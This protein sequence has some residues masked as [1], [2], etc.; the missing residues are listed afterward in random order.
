MAIQFSVPLINPT[1]RTANQSI[2]LVVSM[3]VSDPVSKAIYAMDE[4]QRQQWFFEFNRTLR[5]LHFMLPFDIN[6]INAN[7]DIGRMSALHLFE[8]WKN[9]KGEAPKMLVAMTNA[10]KHVDSGT[11][12]GIFKGRTDFYFPYFQKLDPLKSIEILTP[13]LII[14]AKGD[15]AGNYVEQTHFAN[16]REFAASYAGYW[17]EV[18]Q[19]IEAGGDAAIAF[20]RKLVAAA[21][22]IKPED[23]ANSFTLGT[24]I[25]IYGM[26][27]LGLSFVGKKLYQWSLT[28]TKKKGRKR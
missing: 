19:A 28:D 16:L 11:K 17:M 14:N 20:M 27:A 2:A 12:Q 22:K 4:G 9:A 13:Q 8:F 18:G 10:F 25:F 21:N 5:E 15:W 1:D 26:S 3:T 24:K 6:A 7:I 23:L